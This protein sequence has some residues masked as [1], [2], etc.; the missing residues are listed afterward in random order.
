MLMFVGN[1]TRD[2]S[3]IHPI[4]LGPVP[5]GPRIVAGIGGVEHKDRKALAMREIGQAFVIT[6]AGF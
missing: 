3:R 1:V 6:A 5:T 2:Q 4:G